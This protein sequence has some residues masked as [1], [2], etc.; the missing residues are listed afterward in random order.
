MVRTM[1]A[2]NKSLQETKDCF[3]GC[4]SCSQTKQ[5]CVH[6]FCSPMFKLLFK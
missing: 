5:Q 6:V 4:L 2:V 1:Q 3:K